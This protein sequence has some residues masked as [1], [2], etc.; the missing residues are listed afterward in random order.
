MVRGLELVGWG[1]RWALERL[2]ERGGERKFFVSMG[3]RFGIP[4]NNLFILSDLPSK[5]KWYIVCFQ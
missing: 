2:G 5:G 4:K 3:V 1:E